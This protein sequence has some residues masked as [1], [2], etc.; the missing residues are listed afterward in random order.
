MKP[1]TREIAMMV[2]KIY[3]YSS[4]T[5]ARVPMQDLTLINAKY[6]N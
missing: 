1:N 4:S 3:S 5:G 2:V 6:L